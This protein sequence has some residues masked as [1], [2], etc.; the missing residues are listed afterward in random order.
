M[1][2]ISPICGVILPQVDSKTMMKV[3]GVVKNYLGISLDPKI[4]KKGGYH[5]PLEHV[6]E[7]LM[8]SLR[9]DYFKKA[10]IINTSEETVAA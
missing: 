10:K 3:S 8:N 5:L 7:D 1:E 6:V 2:V 4:V 9:M